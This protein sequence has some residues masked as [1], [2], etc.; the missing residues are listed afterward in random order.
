MEARS[1]GNAIKVRYGKVLLSGS[2][3]SGKTSFFRLLMKKKFEDQYKSTGLADAHRVIFTTKAYIQPSTSGENV[4][5]EVLDFESEIA[6]LR[7]YVHTKINNAASLSTVPDTA[8]KTSESAVE[9]TTTSELITEI[10]TV[11]ADNSETEQTPEE[12]T[13]KIECTDKIW[14]ILTFVD[15][16]G[17]PEYISMLPAVNNSVMLTFVVHKM[18]GGVASLDSPVTVVHSGDHCFKPY[19]LGYSNLDLIKTLISFTDNVFLQKKPS[20]TTF[21]CSLKTSL[22]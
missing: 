14:D 5:F 13:K 3:A 22:D 8:H 12:A 4:E 7:S 2:C 21:V 19:S 20:L 11:I 17:Q 18:E 6:Q 10:E 9:A 15:T 16:G 1:T